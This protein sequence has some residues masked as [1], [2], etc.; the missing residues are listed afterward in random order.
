MS[1][2][3]FNKR[4]IQKLPIKT[5]QNETIQIQINWS[6][7]ERLRAYWLI[8]GPNTDKQCADHLKRIRIQSSVYPTWRIS[9]ASLR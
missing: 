8:N 5:E 6:L 7:L 4:I 3:D 2:E 1:I 9:T